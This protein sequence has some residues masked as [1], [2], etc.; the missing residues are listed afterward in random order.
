MKKLKI[1]IG[2]DKDNIIYNLMGHFSPICI[3]WKRK[4]QNNEEIR[5]G[6]HKTP[7]Y[8]INGTFTSSRLTQA[9]E[10]INCGLCIKDE[11]FE[12]RRETLV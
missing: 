2:L 12:K 10:N 9:A 1:A 8:R 11:S 3:Q 7:T 4:N 6:L 5:R